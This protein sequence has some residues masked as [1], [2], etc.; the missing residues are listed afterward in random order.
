MLASLVQWGDVGTWVAGLATAGAFIVTAAV[1]VMQLRD[2][3]REDAR[4]ISAW[5]DS[6]NYGT[7][8]PVYDVKCRNGSPEPIYLVLIVAGGIEHGMGKVLNVLGPKSTQ[9]VAISVPG[10]VDEEGKV[11]PIDPPVHI[12]F[13]DAAGRRWGREPDGRLIRSKWWKSLHEPVG[14]KSIQGMR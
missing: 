1:F 10:K 7:S 14:M 8:P 3:R 13:T 5:V 4:Q 9:M 12:R 11:M 6:R 2:R